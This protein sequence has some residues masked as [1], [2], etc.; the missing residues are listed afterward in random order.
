MFSINQSGPYVCIHCGFD[1]ND[2]V[3]KTYGKDKE[4]DKGLHRF[5]RLPS[6]LVHLKLA[7]CPKCN[8]PVDDYIELDSCILFIDAAL[9]K[10]RFYR[11]ILV[12]CHYTY[13]VPLKLS[14]VFGLCDSFR[15]WS[16]A[17]QDSSI[18]QSYMELEL[19]FYQ[20]FFES[21]LGTLLLH[22][23][24]VALFRISVGSFNF[25][26][27]I[28][29]L[30]V[31]SYVKLINVAVVLWAAEFQSINS[32]LL[33]LVYMFSL[34]Q[35]CRVKSSNKLSLFKALTL[36]AV[37]KLIWLGLCHGFALALGYQ[38]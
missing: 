18:G 32:V 37:A 10:T 25:V 5:G 34:A 6:S 26:N 38:E 19:S 16:S 14:V 30:V 1:A 13:N 28:L 8:N 35:C 31:C 36:I 15:N 21:M 9:Q 27:L 29:S 4:G 22:L 3:Y 20:I 33:E 12:N 23:L 17:H 7:D 24:I 11:H 2:C